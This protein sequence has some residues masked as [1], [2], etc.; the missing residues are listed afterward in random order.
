MARYFGF[1]YATTA[2]LFGI[3]TCIQKRSR[4]FV[5]CIYF[6]CVLWIMAESFVGIILLMFGGFIRDLTLFLLHIQ[7]YYYTASN[8]IQGRN[9]KPIGNDALS[10]D[11]EKTDA[12][13]TD[14][15]DNWPKQEELIPEPILL[16]NEPI[17]EKAKPEIKLEV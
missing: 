3:Q 14:D 5:S 10:V 8:A 6:L 1:L 11:D 2:F 15:R 13:Y 16:V 12:T 9:P 17:V 7:Y 4:S